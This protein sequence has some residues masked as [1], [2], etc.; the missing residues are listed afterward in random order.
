MTS[1]KALSPSIDARHASAVSES[2][3]GREESQ[4]GGY[5]NRL[6][7]LPVIADASRI[8]HASPSERDADALA[9]EAA[10]SRPFLRFRPE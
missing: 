8:G 7:T 2:G 9:V 1:S 6:T 4:T 5:V 10:N 3:T